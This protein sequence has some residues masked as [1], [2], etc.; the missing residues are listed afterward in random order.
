MDRS[1]VRDA[2]GEQHWRCSPG[3]AWFRQRRCQAKQW[4]YAF[5]GIAVM[6]AFIHHRQR[7]LWSMA[8]VMG[9][10]CGALYFLGVILSRITYRPRAGSQPAEVEPKQLES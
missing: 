6:E 7:I 9:A 1:C 4:R 3:S 2:A 10:T 5:L 8:L